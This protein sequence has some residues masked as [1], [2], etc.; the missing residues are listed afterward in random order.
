MAQA[1]GQRHID[2]CIGLCVRVRV[3]VCAIL[4]L[5]RI[6]FL[7]IRHL[8]FVIASVIALR[9]PLVNI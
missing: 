7:V 6:S 4:D 8:Y 5:A 1:E 2:V 3:C 9:L